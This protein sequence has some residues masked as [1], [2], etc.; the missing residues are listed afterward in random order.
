MKEIKNHR[1]LVSGGGFVSACV[2]FIA[3]AG[4]LLEMPRLASLG[5]GFV[6]MAPSTALLFVAYGVSLLLARRAS[7][8]RRVKRII[9]SILAFG[10]FISLL[11]FF[12]S[13]N[14]V[15]LDL[16]HFG[17]KVLG[18]VDGTPIGHMSPIVA[19]TFLIISLTFPAMLASRSEKA[20]PTKAAWWTAVLLI[21]VYSMLLLAYLFGTPMFYGAAFVP[22]AATTSLAFV[23]LAIALSALSRPLA[24][25]E[26]YGGERESYNSSRVLI[27]VFIF[28]VAGIIS[29]GYFFHTNHQRQYLAEV[30]EQLMAIADLKMGEL[31]LWREERLADAGIF[32]G[33]AAFASHVK[34]ILQNPKEVKVRREIVTWTG[35]LL[36]NR[37]YNRILLLDPRGKNIF[38]LP[39]IAA[40]PLSRFLSQKAVESMRTGKI[41]I[42]DFDR[43]EFSGKIYMSVLVPIFDPAHREDALGVLVMR[44]DPEKYLYPFIKRWPTTSATAES[45]LVRMEGSRAIYLNELRFKGNA[46]LNFS[47]PMAQTETPA[48]MAALGRVGVVRGIDYRGHSVTAVLKTIPDS[49]W[50]LVTQMDDEEIYAPLRDRQ[51]MTIFLVSSMLI[52]TG[53]TIGFIWRQQNISY[54]RR[55]KIQIRSNRER[56]QCLQNIFQFESTDVKE[57]LDYALNEALGMTSSKYGYIFYYD[58]LKKLFTLN[59]RS[60][61]VMQTCIDAELQSL[62]ELDKTGIWGEAV[63]QRRPIMVNDF[64]AP[65]PLKKGCPEGHVL[66]TRFLTIPHFDQGKIVA[67]IGMANKESAYDDSDVLQLALLSESVWKIAER[68]RVEVEMANQTALI[69]AIIN[70]PSD[71]LIFSLDSSYCYTAFNHPHAAEMKK[72]FGVDIAIGSSILSYFASKDL[73]DL[74]KADLDRGLAG[75]SFHGQWKVPENDI[76]FE[77]A[78]SP[79][80][81]ASGTVTGV[82]VFAYDISESVH[83]REEA[84]SRSEELALALSSLKE[85]QIQIIHQEKMASIGQLAAGVA[86]EINNPMGYITSNMNSLWKYTEKLARFIEVQEQAIEQCSDEETKKS[87]SDLKRQ[88]KLDFVMKDFREL[89]VESLD[90]SKRVSKI[91]QDLKSFSRIE[92]NDAVT[93]DLNECIRSA[94]N[95]V[96]NEIKYV[97]ELDITLGD[98]PLV[99]CRPQQIS[100]VVMNLLVNASHSISGTG[101]IS[102]ATTVVNDIVEISITDTGCGIPTENIGKIFEPFFTT[103]EL[104]KGT[105]LGLAISCDIVRNH[106]GELLVK[107]EVGKG[108]TFTLRL[109][110]DGERKLH[111]ESDPYSVCR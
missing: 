111:H 53:A 7:S 73:H 35:N 78:L 9:Q 70:S 44:I 60:H 30:E 96:R 22:P 17:I 105:G 48:V 55:S 26:L 100:Q 23:A 89:I 37:N 108:T 63:R 75:E 95:I 94:L 39:D 25:P 87:I 28:L 103:K 59:S 27:V 81:A 31:V 29:A 92:G 14:G 91:V 67:V 68:R 106:G 74:F 110:V 36:K 107:S 84:D 65:D 72:L 38:S 51:W 20:W 50:R 43:N 19:F 46:A 58:E 40:E 49:P 79:V 41:N 42:A 11:L 109:P 15:Y 86:H 93:T 18:A 90:G 104:G 52:G 13:I 2:G 98:I 33:N 32:Y 77:M 61:G 21:A 64:D 83:S 3:L 69:S 76:F 47:A 57:L 34:N 56:L 99:I 12:L 45:L 1:I 88:I 85:A 80:K 24:W 4:W 8:N 66:L 82:A 5:R 16:E 97:A 71:I 54:Y 10:V 102:L 6:P 101:V 62:Y